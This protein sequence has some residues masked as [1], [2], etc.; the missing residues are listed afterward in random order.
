MAVERE[1]DYFVLDVMP[2]SNEVLVWKQ[3]VEVTAK[4]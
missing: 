2:V 3:E 1:E 4:T